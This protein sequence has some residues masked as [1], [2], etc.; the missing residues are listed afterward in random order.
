[1]LAEWLRQPSKICKASIWKDVSLGVRQPPRNSF[2]EGL[3][4]FVRKKKISNLGG[5]MAVGISE[6]PVY[7]RFCLERKQKCLR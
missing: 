7:M 6:A 1:M 4:V 2:D 5:R 3:K